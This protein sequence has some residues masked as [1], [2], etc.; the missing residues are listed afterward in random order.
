MIFSY[1]YIIR[2]KL[3]L[4]KILWKYII[5]DEGHRMKNSRS[6]LSTIL[7]TEYRSENRLLLSGKI[8][9]NITRYSTT[10]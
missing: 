6:K 3:R 2:D 5:I 8:I 7:G 9:H 4:H 1:D 10:E